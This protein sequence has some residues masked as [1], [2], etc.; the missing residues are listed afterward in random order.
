ML[1]RIYMVLAI[2]A[3]SQTRAGLHSTPAMSYY[4]AAMEHAQ[5]ALGLIGD[6]MEC[7]QAHLLVLLFSLQHDIGSKLLMYVV[8][9]W[10]E[11]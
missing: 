1:F 5:E 11:S 4:V 6:G 10:P 9:V 3:V 8:Y 7:I 2:G